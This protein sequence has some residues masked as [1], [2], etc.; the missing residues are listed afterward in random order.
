MVVDQFAGALRSL[1]PF[2]A[3]FSIAVAP[4]TN[5]NRATD[6]QTLDTIIAPLDLSEDARQRSGIGLKVGAQAFARLP[7]SNR[8]MLVPRLSGQSELCRESRFNDV[9]GS[10]L[11]GLEYAAG[12]DRL[13]P[14]IGATWRM[15]GGEPYARTQT[16]SIDWLHPVGQRAQIATDA[17]VSRARYLQNPLQDGWLYDGGVS[18]ERAFGAGSGGTLSLRATRQTARDPGY[19][20]TSGGVSLLHYR[21]LGRMT[22]FGSLGLRRLEGDARLFLFTDRRREW[23]LSSSV[24]ATFRQ[25]S[26]AGFAPLVR[27]SYE[28]NWSAVGIYDY[29]RTAVEFGV[30]RAF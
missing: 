25:A 24:G 20:T 26:V 27:L 10:V 28:R 19:S 7:L 13:R 21:E 2:G 11:L 15:Y 9:S 12:R 5:I 29:G 17:S 22:A 8:L 30:T 6:A 4:D 18:Y 14:S 1:K 3:S 16:A 23:L